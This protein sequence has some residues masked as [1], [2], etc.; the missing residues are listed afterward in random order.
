MKTCKVEGCEKKVVCKGLCNA[1]YIKYQRYG[2]PL[3]GSWSWN[4]KETVRIPSRQF[5]GLKKCAHEGCERL[6]NGNS[7]YCSKH[8][9][10][11]RKYGTSEPTAL[12]KSNQLSYKERILDR[13]KVNEETDC[14]EWQARCEDKMG[15][16]LF[17]YKGKLVHAHRA[18]Y[19]ELVGPIPKGL[20]VLHKCDNPCCVNPNHLFLGDAKANSDDKIMKQRQARGEGQGGAKLTEK[21]VIAIR[22]RFLSFSPNKSMSSQCNSIAEDFNVSGKLIRNIYQGKVWKHVSVDK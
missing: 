17:W 19:M 11:I 18:I 12:M 2:D 8:L 14:W 3:G 1:H 13:I 10:R 7:D 16:G 20:Y 5:G 21:D 22:E 6:N 4:R 15:Y 9:Q